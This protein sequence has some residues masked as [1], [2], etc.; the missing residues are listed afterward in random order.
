M[1]SALASYPTDNEPDPPAEAAVPCPVSVLF[2]DVVGSTRYFKAKG[3]LAGRRMLQRHLDLVAGPIAA[4]QGHL[5]KTIGDSVLAYFAFAN[6]ALQAAVAI[7]QQLKRHN[8]VAVKDD[9][10]HVRIAV[11][12]GHGLIEQNDIFGDV[13][14]V[15]AKILPLV[16]S[17]QI[18][19]SRAFYDNLTVAPDFALEKIETHL[20][21]VLGQMDVYNVAWDPQMPLDPGAHPLVVL[22]A[23]RTG[24]GRIYLDE[25]AAMAQWVGATA[26][27]DD[28][29]ERLVV[30]CPTVE[31]ALDLACRI[32]GSLRDR[33]GCF[34]PVQCLVDCGPADTQNPGDLDGL[35]PGNPWVSAAARNKS[36]RVA[37]MTKPMPE[38]PWYCVTVAQIP[39][40]LRS[41]WREHIA[42]GPHPPCFYCGDRRHIAADCP[43]KQADAPPGALEEIGRMNTDQLEALLWQQITQAAS[44][45]AG[46][47]VAA[48]AVSEIGFVHQT[49]MLR[50]VW[51]FQGRSWSQALAQEGGTCRRSGAIWLAMDCLRSGRLEQAQSLLIGRGVISFQ[52]LT[53]QALI[54][55][56]QGRLD[57]AEAVLRQTMERVLSPVQK[58]YVLFLIQR[59]CRL[60]GQSSRAARALRRIK[61]IFPDCAQAIYEEIKMDL[62]AGR[63]DRA[64]AG[65]AGLI[66]RHPQYLAIAWVDPDLAGFEAIIQPRLERILEGCRQQVGQQVEVTGQALE[67]L[68]RFAG[69]NEP[70]VV[71]G[72]Q[73]LENLCGLAAS[74]SY[75]LM[76]QALDQAALLREKIVGQIDSRRK[77]LLAMIAAAG[78]VFTVAQAWRQ[79]FANPLKTAAEGSRLEAAAAE[80]EQLRASLQETSAG[81]VQACADCLPRI[82]AEVRQIAI[83]LEKRWHRHQLKNFALALGRRLL[84]WQGLNVILGMLVLPLTNRVIG[85]LAP[86]ATL[87]GDGLALG[88]AALLTI[89]AAIGLMLASGQAFNR[90]YIERKSGKKAGR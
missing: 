10:I 55:A 57:R 65:L 20:P 40:P 30:A 66:R 33:H 36:H 79:R 26:R 71:A 28:A 86:N 47:N 34:V 89:G 85:L 77:K 43:T 90:V 8:I 76:N 19:V 3:D 24:Y 9:Q 67:R 50:L 35:P 27:V 68:Q 75:V 74:G 62:R 4:H 11:H 73:E 7:Q 2:T 31:D 39:S 37:A 44:S 72:R 82:V 61:A 46:P 49:G 22:R 70:A 56:E 16:G 18:A 54:H 6:A 25:A 60:M 88:Q 23:W 48:A 15:A 87:S 38:F 78:D 53:V 83:G 17:D 58:A 59:V 42:A 52:S 14:N 84:M 69:D 29:H 51:D 81:A 41:A 32:M 63:L 80:L 45:A 12:H 21:P 1:E 64:A 13:V 5:V